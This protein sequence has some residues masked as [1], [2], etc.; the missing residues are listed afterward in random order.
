MSVLQRVLALTGAV[1]VS[2]G[3]TFSPLQ[4]H[5][6]DGCKVMLCMAGNWRNIQACEPEVRRALRDLARGRHWPGCQ[7]SN[8]PGNTSAFS[9]VSVNDCPV[10]YVYVEGYFADGRPI[11]ACR[12]LYVVRV[13]VDG[14]PWSNTFTDANGDSVTQ[15]FPAARA[16]LAGSQAAA[17]NQFDLDYAAWVAA[18][19]ANNGGGA[20][21][22][23]GT[24]P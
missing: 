16:A 20:G 10:Q 5:A 24:G 11:Y 12:Y 1:V 8:G 18:Q 15:W 17:D 21:G 3:G 6:A 9:H 2:V 13:V 4:A 23:P 7:T 19:A 14:V 22:N